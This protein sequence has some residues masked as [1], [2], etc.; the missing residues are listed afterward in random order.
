MKLGE[1]IEALGNVANGPKQHTAKSAVANGNLSKQAKN[2][3][4]ARRAVN[5]KELCPELAK[6]EKTLE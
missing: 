6:L 4:P 3:P 5:W 1:V 2:R